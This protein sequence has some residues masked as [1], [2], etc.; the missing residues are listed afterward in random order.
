MDFLAIKTGIFENNQFLFLGCFLHK[1]QLVLKHSFNSTSSLENLITR[2]KN[3]VN[4]F[5]KQKYKRYEILLPTF[6]ETRW[7]S[8][9]RIINSILLKKDEIILLLRKENFPKDI[10]KI[11]DFPNLNF[12]NKILEQ[13]NIITKMLEVDSGNI[14]EFYKWYKNFYDRVKIESDN[15]KRP[16][17]ILTLLKNILKNFTKY[18]ENDFILLEPAFQL[19][20][21]LDPSHHSNI[22]S[23]L[24]LQIKERITKLFVK[25]HDKTDLENND[26]QIE[27]ESEDFFSDG[28]LSPTLQNET[29]EESNFDIK[30]ELL[31][32]EK[33][34]SKL[35][36]KAEEYW[37]IR[38]NRFAKLHKLYVVVSE[39]TCA[40]GSIERLFSLLKQYSVWKR[41]RVSVQTMAERISARYK[42]D[43]F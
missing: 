22:D 19:L 5:R 1:L 35:N 7:N 13:F 32:F 20:K 29:L 9:Y 12:L 30:K 33:E 25:S 36:M 39:I 41:N 16:S 11:N 42:D 24:A 14:W 2:I 37:R 23:V 28:F 10:I 21:Y 40:N 15:Q 31:D 38:K 34:A 43:I 6:S 27:L 17:N 4:I 26:E 8:I 3:T 18:F